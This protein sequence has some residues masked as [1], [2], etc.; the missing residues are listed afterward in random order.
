MLILSINSREY[1]I[2]Y[3][4]MKTLEFSRLLASKLKQIDFVLEPFGVNQGQL[5][6]EPILTL[7][8]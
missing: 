6:M 8:M 1:K 3:K 5:E 4:H 2:E 7:W